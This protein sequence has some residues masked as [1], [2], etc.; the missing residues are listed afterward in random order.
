MLSLIT[1]IRFHRERALFKRTKDVDGLVPKICNS[2]TFCYNLRYIDWTYLVISLQWRHMIVTA[3]QITNH[4]TVCQQLIKAYN[5]GNCFHV[6]MPSNTSLLFRIVVPCCTWKSEQA[7]QD[8]FPDS[9]VHGANM[10]PIWVLSA[11]DGPH[12]GPMNLAIR[13]GATVSYDNG[14]GR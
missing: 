14:N 9:K 7:I 11:P 3:S 1:F 2:G 10:G 5:K 4:S 12:V 8:V 13:V 6:I